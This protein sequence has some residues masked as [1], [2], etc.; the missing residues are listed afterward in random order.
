MNSV[1]Q[2]AS[3][4]VE[5]ATDYYAPGEYHD[6]IVSV[7]EGK[8][9]RSEETRKVRWTPQPG[10]DLSSGVTVADLAKLPLGQHSVEVSLVDAA[11]NVV[12]KWNADVFLD[13][14]NQVRVVIA[15]GCKT[16]GC[17]NDNGTLC[18]LCI[19][20][21][22]ASTQSL[23]VAM[24][25]G[26][27]STGGVLK[28]IEEV[29]QAVCV[30]QFCQTDAECGPV[31]ECAQAKCVEGVCMHVIKPRGCHEPFYCNPNPGQGCVAP[32]G[33]L[34]GALCVPEG[35]ECRV[36]Y[37]RCEEN[38]PMYCDDVNLWR[39]GTPC[40]TGFCSGR[41]NCDAYVTHDA[42]TGFD[43]FGRELALLG[44]QLVAHSIHKGPTHEGTT[45]VYDISE[46]GVPALSE[47]WTADQVAGAAVLGFSA[48][49]DRVALAKL[50][51]TFDSSARV[52]VRRRLPDGDWVGDP[53]VVDPNGSAT[54]NAAAL[55]GVPTALHDNTLL[56]AD[57]ELRVNH[58][59]EGVVHAYE[60]NGNIWSYRQQLGASDAAAYDYFGEA[61]AVDGDRLAIG[62]Q[63]VNS[64]NGAGATVYIFERVAGSWVE[65][66]RFG[67]T[68]STNAYDIDALA[69][70]GDY[71]AMTTLAGTTGEVSIFHY[72]AGIDLWEELQI[73][74]GT[75]AQFLDQDLLVRD[76][77]VR[78]DN[79]LHSAATL[80]RFD[81][82]RTWTLE[83]QLVA[84]AGG[85]AGNGTSI[86]G[87]DKWI[88]LG[89]AGENKSEGALYIFHRDW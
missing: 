78:G 32:E 37:W 61:V 17:T 74:S 47:T 58:T 67:S 3:L 6:V 41:G 35:E 75:S 23:A 57:T 49:T 26:D 39:A 71:L 50:P 30:N 46:S 33:T 4:H 20:N 27:D 15:R 79:K 8:T 14:H 5:L 36:G 86:A 62:S 7:G 60:F 44:D 66:H 85:P 82:N 31:A 87:N 45:F 72:D 24:K 16:D 1:Q 10:D 68:L 89:A 22:C 80:Y 12:A 69:L 81:G 19:D 43:Q 25:A 64:T 48:S 73:L 54:G 42:P 65:K 77:D 40:S 88:A 21:T 52:Y 53:P 56:V 13:G 11:E 84:Y 28:K 2:V 83:K 9:Q 51:G 76:P 34:C 38:Q 70:S 63:K 29:T 55:F 18:R 59:R